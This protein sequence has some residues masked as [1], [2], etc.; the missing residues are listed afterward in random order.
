MA[1]NPLN[2]PHYFGPRVRDDHVEP[3]NLAEQ[4]PRFSSTDACDGQRSTEPRIA[5]DGCGY[6]VERFFTPA[7]PR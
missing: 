4:R 7:T 2:N 6:H 5:P 1:T 3:G